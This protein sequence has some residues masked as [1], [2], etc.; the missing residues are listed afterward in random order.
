MNI[1]ILEHPV[2]EIT[3]SMCGLF[4]LCF[5]K[6]IFNPDERSKIINHETPNKKTIEQI[7]NEIFSTDVNQNEHEI[8]NFKKEYD[9]WIF[10]DFIF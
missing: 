3:S 6:N 5:Y 8:K 7:L 1:L 4:Q 9:L 10:S 2:Q